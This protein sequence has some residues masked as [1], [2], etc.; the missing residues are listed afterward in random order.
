MFQG[1]MFTYVIYYKAAVGKRDV[2]HMLQV[3]MPALQFSD[4]EAKI[5]KRYT[6]YRYPL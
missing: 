2:M 5:S 6:T 3:E 1:K 4:I